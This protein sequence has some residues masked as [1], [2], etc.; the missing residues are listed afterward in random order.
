MADKLVLRY[1]EN[2]DD[3][4]ELRSRARMSI[5]T[6]PLMI[7]FFETWCESMMFGAEKIRSEF[8]H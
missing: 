1:A 2:E 6:W 5:L 8:D 4:L 3:L 7:N